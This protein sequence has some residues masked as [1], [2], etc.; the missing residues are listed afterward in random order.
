MRP[1]DPIEA[2]ASPADIG[3]QARIAAGGQPALRAA[4]N[5]ILRAVDAF[6]ESVL[7][8]ALVGGGG[9]GLAKVLVRAYF[10]QSF[11]WADGAARLSLSILA[12][13]GGAVAYRRR[14]H[15]FVRVVL[16]LVSRRSERACLALADVVVLFV[17]GL[18]GIASAEFITSSWTERTPILQLPAALIA[19]PLPVARAL[20][21]LYDLANFR[22]EHGRMAWG[23]GGPFVGVMAAAAATRDFWL[24]QLGGDAAIL[25][26]PAL[27]FAPI[28]AGVPVGFVLL[29]ATATYLW[30]TAAASLVVLPQAMEN[31]AGH[32]ILLAMPLFILDGLSMDRD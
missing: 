29:L 15:A 17:A 3:V 4:P 32:F 22:G 27:F 25:A 8:A 31:G 24:P 14:D 28:F 1:H 26:A 20:L 19:L 6:A 18:T 30:G 2:L 16:N 9:L 7:G 13:I 21:A 11:L 12:F 10:Q 23:V 5:A